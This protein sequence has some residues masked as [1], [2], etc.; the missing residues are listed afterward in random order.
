M[1]RPIL[2]SAMLMST[3]VHAA[4]HFRFLA[5]GDSYTIGESV[6]EAERWPEQLTARLRHQGIHIDAPVIVARTGWTTDELRDA[7]RVHTIRDTFDVV[8]LLIGVNDQYRGRSVV[9][10]RPEFVALLNEAIRFT[11]GVASHVIVLSIPDWGATPFAGGRNR[12]AIAH[13]ID[14]FNTVNREESKRAGVHYVDITDLSR[15][16]REDE[17]L[18]ADD[19][20][21]PSPKL[22]GQWVGR[23]EPIAREVLSKSSRK[24]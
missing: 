13:G 12:V 11:G 21:H 16:A 1:I 6:Q 3:L 17:S 4:P 10:Y 19:G 7:V 24:E 20:L 5:L 23:V 8:S 22:Y 2:L 14:S 9:D 18:V 15:K